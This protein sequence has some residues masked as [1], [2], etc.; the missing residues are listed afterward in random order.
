MGL[1]SR[2]SSSTNARRETMM[3]NLSLKRKERVGKKRK[4]NQPGWLS[5]LTMRGSTNHARGTDLRGIGVAPK[6]VENAMEYTVRTN[7]RAAKELQG[8]E[9][10]DKSRKRR[11][12][13]TKRS[14][15]KNLFRILRAGTNLSEGYGLGQWGANYV[16]GCTAYETT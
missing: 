9:R 3:I 12:I 13:L 2:K 14:P 11:T 16:T 10:R 8:K 6:L 4:I 1:S 15:S 7:H 5:A